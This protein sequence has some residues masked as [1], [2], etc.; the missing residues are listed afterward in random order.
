MGKIGRPKS[1]D[2][3]K[4][5]SITIKT[6]L[7]NRL[8]KKSKKEETSVSALMETAAEQKYPVEK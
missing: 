7:I 3:R 1:T 5:I 2:P 4:T 6:S 8:K